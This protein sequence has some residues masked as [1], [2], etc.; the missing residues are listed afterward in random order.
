MQ[1]PKTWPSEAD[2]RSSVAKRIAAHL[3]G[4]RRGPDEEILIVPWTKKHGLYLLVIDEQP[5][6]VASR[7]WLRSY[8][9]SAQLFNYD[10]RWTPIGPVLK[11]KAHPAQQTSSASPD[12]DGDGKGDVYW[13]A[14]DL[15]YEYEA[16][17]RGSLGRMNPVGRYTP[18]Y[19]DVG[20]QKGTLD[21]GDRDRLYWGSD[22]QVHI[23]PTS[24]G[25]WTL[26]AEDHAVLVRLL[27]QHGAQRF[28]GAVTWV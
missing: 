25:C 13:S 7:E 22:V 12:I 20:G 23:G 3:R 9:G 6:A 21:S 18:G 4:W 28:Y 26:P 10:G 2:K 16:R 11:A 1:V 8:T 5:P 15:V 24:I 27:R 17:P 14:P 19:R